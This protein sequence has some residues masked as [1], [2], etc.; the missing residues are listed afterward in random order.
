MTLNLYILNF[1]ILA[2]VWIGSCI[3]CTVIEFV[4]AR[5]MMLYIRF[6]IA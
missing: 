5:I 2:G 1:C 4:F 6:I 3:Y